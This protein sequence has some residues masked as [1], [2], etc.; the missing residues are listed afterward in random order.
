MSDTV[1][2]NAKST[3]SPG[4]PR[5]ALGRTGIDLSMLGFGG[6]HLVE[7]PARAADRL[8][9]R[10]L[11]EGGNY[12][13]TAASYG[14]GASEAKIGAAVAHRRAEYHLATKTTQRTAAG[15]AQDLENS[16]RRLQTD[17]VDVFFMH[18][19]G[20]L[21]DLEAIL[22][23][24]GALEAAVQARADGK[25]R[26]IGITAHGLPEALIGALDEYPFDVLM[27]GMNYYDRFNF[28]AVEASLIPKAQR[29]G[30]GLLA[31]KPIADGFL[32]RSATA[33]FRFTWGLPVTAIVAGINT[34]EQL[35]ADLNWARRWTPMTEAE[36]EDLFRSAPEL[37]TY[38]CRQCGECLPCAAGIDIPR[39][40]ELEGWYD[41][42]MRD[43]AVRDPAEYGMRERL[44]FWFNNKDRAREAY[45]ALPVKA[46]RCRALRDADD[47]RRGSEIGCSDC[48]VRCP[49]GLNI[50]SK[51]DYADFKLGGDRLLF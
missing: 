3:A 19:V 47:G 38:V 18:S 10:Y 51:L 8:L 23:P 4:L 16:L 26:F 39:V 11:D 46:G 17:H 50:P 43:G 33:A 41:R 2:A 35:A 34:E 45:A 6:F 21:K 5:R 14:D 22:A 7:I 44:R 13:E 25:T 48:A 32:W 29:L 20:T 24:E 1:D 40:F 36:R 12:L 9:N 49:Y 28:P 30:A 31:M 42:Q 27:T 15:A 37:G